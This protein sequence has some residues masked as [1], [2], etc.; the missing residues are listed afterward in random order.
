L[1]VFF[2]FASFECCYSIVY[3]KKAAEKERLK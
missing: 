1:Y 3:I 2:V